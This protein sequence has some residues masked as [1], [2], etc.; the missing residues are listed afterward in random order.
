[1]YMKKL[2]T[3]FLFLAL[4]LCNPSNAFAEIIGGIDFPSGEISFADFIVSYTVGDDVDAAHSDS[5]NALG[6][7]DFDGED[8]T[9][10]YVSLGHGGSMVL[11]FTDNSLTASGDS[12]LDLYIFEIGGAEE[13]TSVSISSDGIDWISVGIVS[14]A[15]KGLI[16]M[17]S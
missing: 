10:G 11:Q 4:L 6:I 15:Q 9:L 13:A 3:F 17:P 5:N 12:F 16:L 7:P 14:G 2:L 8:A 1:M